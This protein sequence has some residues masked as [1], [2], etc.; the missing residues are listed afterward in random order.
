M[1][2]LWMLVQIWDKCYS[3]SN[4]TK[5]KI[6]IKLP[7]TS[8]GTGGLALDLNWFKSKCYDISCKKKYKIAILKDSILFQKIADI[9]IR[10]SFYNFH[11]TDNC[12]SHW[13][14]ELGI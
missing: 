8:L 12:G 5:N 11:F 6:S 14:F 10:D 9:I 1:K 3:S 2:A 4:L 7:F 13:Y